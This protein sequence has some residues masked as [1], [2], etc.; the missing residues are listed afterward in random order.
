MVIRVNEVTQA[1]N[2]VSVSETKETSSKDIQIYESQ[3]KQTKEIQAKRKEAAEKLEAQIVLELDLEDN[4]IVPKI[5]EKDGK[6]FVRLKRPDNDKLRPNLRQDFNM[7]AIKKKLGIDD[8]VLNKYNDLGDVTGRSLYENSDGGVM[9][10][11]KYIDVPLEELGKA[12]H[13]GPDFLAPMLFK[14]LRQSV[15]NYTSLYE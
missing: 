11:G 7:G 1:S 9:E 12:V 8:G 6:H 15:E 10:A 3:N 4:F 14:K 13:P 2:N 5:I